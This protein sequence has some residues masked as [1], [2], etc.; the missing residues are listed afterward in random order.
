MRGPAKRRWGGALGLLSTLAAACSG[1]RERS[2]PGMTDV[3]FEVGL[4]QRVF[5]GS[6]QKGHIRE[7][8]GQGACWIDHDGDGDL[9]LFLPNGARQMLASYEP[10][11]PRLAPWRLYE[12]VGGRF[13]D[14][15]AA[16]G[17]PATAWGVGCAVGDVDADGRDDLYVTAAAGGS[18]LLR[19]VGGTFVD[20]SGPSGTRIGAFTTSALFFDREG[21]A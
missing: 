20:A 12:N 10:G 5:S 15:R 1:S 3:A 2:R 18:R 19:N 17:P 8:V 9:D 11:D 4:G 6:T 16:L 21:D 14:Q 13:V 7:T